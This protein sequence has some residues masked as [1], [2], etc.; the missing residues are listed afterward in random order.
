[1]KRYLLPLLLSSAVCFPTVADERRVDFDIPPQPLAQALEQLARQTGL[2]LL[3]AADSTA[4]KTSPRVSGRYTPEQALEQLLK[5]S[6]LSYRFTD[7]YTAVL[8]QTKASENNSLALGNKD[9]LHPVMLETMV[10][11]AT[12]TERLASEVSAT[13]SVIDDKQISNMYSRDLSDVLQR[14]AGIDINRAGSTGIAT[15]NLRGLGARKSS[16]LINGQYSEFLDLG[17][18]T[19]N[20]MQTIDWDNVQQVEIVR[21]AGSALYGPN[22]MGG[23]V[24]IITKDA[25]EANNV[26]KPFFIFDSLPTY[27]GGFSTGGTINDFSYLLNVKHLSS[28]GYKSTPQPGFFP[29]SSSTSS[30]S[31]NKG[32]WEKTLVGGMLDYRFSADSKLK[33]S[34]NFLDD[35]HNMF[36]RETI[37]DGQFGQ[38]SMEYQQRL[39]DRFDITANIG[40]R[41]HQAKDVFDNYV[42]PSRPDP[43]AN[44]ILIENAQKLTG[45]LRGRWQPIE[46]HTLLF[47]YNAAQDWT[48][49]RNVSPENGDISDRRKADITNHGL[50]LQY[51]LALW[52]R[53]FLTA[54]GRYDWFDYTLDARIAPD[55]HR[56]SNYTFSSFNP[57]GGIRFKFNDAFSLRATAGTGYSTP[58]PSSILGGLNSAF[59]EQLP[60]P[61]LQPEQSE[62]FDLGFDLHLPFG[63]VAAITGYYNSLTDYNLVSLQ[64]ENNKTIVQTQNIGKVQTYGVEL[65]LTQYLGENWGLFVNYT[66]NIAEVA[67]ELPA[68]ARGLPEK[69]KQ[70]PLT[71]EDKASFGLLYDSSQLSGRLEGRYVGTRFNGGDTQNSPDYALASYVTADFRL[72]YHYPLSAEQTL[73]IS[74]GINNIFDRRYEPRFINQYAEPRIGFLQLGFQF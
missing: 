22:A 61:D 57:R 65:E 9:H 5:G 15:F 23:V 53:L 17:I 3:Y 4:S 58:A 27:G 55:T 60:N 64:R 54:G 47:G 7:S 51:E 41:D 44:D 20:P 52:D 13:V 46:G 10:V 25:P 14:S 6:G 29:G 72:T 28:D 1:M 67:S 35:K 66:H 33:F 37:S 42:Y 2:Q 40:L 32:D 31:L 16:V 21:G 69:G 56:A 68:T 30:H 19:R 59:V 48:R 8:Q 18:G 11:T 63:L 36:D 49:R 43:S 45:E 50:Y 70:L 73:D 12:K 26:T 62:S 71:P 39:T 74:A 38:Y 24:N 34:Y